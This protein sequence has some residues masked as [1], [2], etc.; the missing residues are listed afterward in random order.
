[1]KERAGG[2][3]GRGSYDMGRLDKGGA[4]VGEGE[5]GEEIDLNEI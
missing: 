5:E 3:G 1:M 4:G 2:G